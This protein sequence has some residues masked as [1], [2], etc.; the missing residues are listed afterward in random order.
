MEYVGSD[1]GDAVGSL[2]DQFKA[3]KQLLFGPLQH[4][5]ASDWTGGTAMRRGGVGD[6]SGLRVLVL[7]GEY[8]MAIELSGALRK[9][10]TVVIRLFPRAEK[11]LPAHVK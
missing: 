11:D 5:V 3:E 7:K 10:G 2:P 9:V 8:L 4:R 6:L 1:Y